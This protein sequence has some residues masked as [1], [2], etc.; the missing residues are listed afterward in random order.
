MNFTDKSERNVNCF[1]LYTKEKIIR[2]L[3]FIRFS[4]AIVFVYCKNK[5]QV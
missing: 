4:W 1:S 5:K 3:E 2:A